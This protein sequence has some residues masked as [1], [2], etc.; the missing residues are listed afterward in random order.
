M[1]PKGKIIPVIC[2]NE[3]RE[4]SKFVDVWSDGTEIRQVKEQ[5]VIYKEN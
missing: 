3:I 1:F 5:L 4:G 2:L